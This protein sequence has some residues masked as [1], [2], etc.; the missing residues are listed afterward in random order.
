MNRL[1][2][3]FASVFLI[4]CTSDKK[5][6]EYIYGV[7]SAKVACTSVEKKVDDRLKMNGIWVLET[8][9]GE[10]LPETDLPRPR[11]EISVSEMRYMGSD[12]CNSLNGSMEKLCEK[13][14]KFGMAASTRMMCPDMQVADLF[15]PTLLKVSSYDVG[16]MQLIL[17][18]EEGNELMQFKKTD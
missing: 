11:I 15:G 1:I 8:L 7:H 18:D 16:D 12:G 6:K 3:F 5:A 13:E 4:S 9:M 10:L 17:R 2:L 14:I